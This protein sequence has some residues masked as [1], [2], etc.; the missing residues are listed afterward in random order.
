MGFGDS[1]KDNVL[2]SYRFVEVVTI[3]VLNIFV[4]EVDHSVVDRRRDQPEI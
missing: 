1:I 4:R 2:V 3:C